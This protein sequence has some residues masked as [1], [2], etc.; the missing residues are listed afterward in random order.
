MRGPLIAA[1]TGAV[2]AVG[3]GFGTAAVLSG[4]ANGQPG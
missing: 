1:L 4:A 2:L 3:A